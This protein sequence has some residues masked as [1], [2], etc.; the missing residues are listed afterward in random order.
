MKRRSPPEEYHEAIGVYDEPLAIAF[1][2]HL[3]VIT[4]NRLEA[5]FAAFNGNEFYL[6]R[7][8]HYRSY[9]VNAAKGLS[10]RRLN[11]IERLGAIR[12]RDGGL[13]GESVFDSWRE[14]ALGKKNRA[15]LHAEKAGQCTDWGNDLVPDHCDLD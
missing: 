12:T 2:K 5:E 10:E 8:V 15:P 9:P 4:T 7:H 11:E 3:G 6:G 14:P 1:R 13:K